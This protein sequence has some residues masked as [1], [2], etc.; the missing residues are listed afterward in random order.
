MIF[1]F[2]LEKE[3][4]GFG[5]GGH[6]GGFG[7]GGYG[8]HTPGRLWNR[9]YPNV[10]GNGYVYNALPC[11]CLAGESWRQCQYRIQYYGCG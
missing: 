7:R 8:Y 9:P 1:L 3:M 6:G 5:R 11:P 4:E 2:R 10:Y